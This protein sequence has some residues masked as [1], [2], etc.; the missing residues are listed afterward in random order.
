MA[1]T[2][3]PVAPADAV[4][5]ENANFGIGFELPEGWAFQDTSESQAALDSEHPGA[6]IEALAVAPDGTAQFVIT[7]EPFTDATADQD[8]ATHAKNLLTSNQDL[9]ITETTIN[10]ADGRQ[11][12]ANLVT[13]EAGDAKV[14]AVYASMKNDKGF[15]DMVIT[16]PTEDDINAILSNLK[17][18]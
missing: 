1:E 5:Y 11:V 15:L 9:E 16:A 8:E 2:S 10:L 12:P 14:V 6:S 7:V 18:L 13:V 17:S 3:A 4:A